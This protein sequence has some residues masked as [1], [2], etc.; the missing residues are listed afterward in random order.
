M[1]PG[2]TIINK[3]S[4]CAKLV[5]QATIGSGNTFGATFWTDGKREAPMLPDPLWLVMCPHCQAPLWVDELEVLGEIDPWGKRDQAFE[6][7]CE[8][9]TPSL[10]NYLALL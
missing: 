10:Q 2:P 8:C 9:Q 6:G 5:E 7:A 1:T 4:A 3:C